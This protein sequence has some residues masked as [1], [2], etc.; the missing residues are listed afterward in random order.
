[1]LTK[2]RD[3]VRLLEEQGPP[4]Q[5]ICYSGDD[6]VPS[7][8]ARIPIRL[9]VWHHLTIELDFY[10]RTYTFYVDGAPLAGPFVFLKRVNTNTLARGSFLAYAAP[11]TP[12]LQKVNY[13]AH[14]D[15]FSIT[16]R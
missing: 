15:N 16:T 1:M 12:T 10:F 13:T 2:D 11:D 5:V 6:N 14:Y 4:P 3:F 9:G 7:F 8:Q